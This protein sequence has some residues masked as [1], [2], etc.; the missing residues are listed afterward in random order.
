[1]S[2]EDFFFFWLLYDSDT[3]F[4]YNELELIQLDMQ[5]AYCVHS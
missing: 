4:V 5:S 1:M 3:C 2:E